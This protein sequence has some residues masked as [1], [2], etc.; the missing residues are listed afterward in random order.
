MITIKGDRI[1]YCDVDD[2]LIMWNE[3]HASYK[4]NETHIKLIK[5][6]KLRGHTI[7]VWSAGGCEWA[8]RIVIELGLEEYV[9]LVICKPSWFCDDLT[10]AEFLPEVNRIYRGKV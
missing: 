9:D 7:V 5:E 2:T 4:A 3:T 10:S 6:H 1:L 8:E